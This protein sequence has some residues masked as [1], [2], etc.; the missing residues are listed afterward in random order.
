MKYSKEERLNIGQKICEGLMSCSEAAQSY[1]ISYSTAR[2]YM[3]LY[4][5]AQQGSKGSQAQGGSVALAPKT[6][7]PMDLS[8]Y[9]N[10]TKEQLIR[11][12]VK[13]RVNEARLKKGYMVKG[14]GPN[15]VY[16]PLGRWITK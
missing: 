11:E 15:K 2:N 6:T 9:E 8:D 13:A 5:E 3:A 14:G 16:L 10:M 7:P 1:G 12:L 4:R